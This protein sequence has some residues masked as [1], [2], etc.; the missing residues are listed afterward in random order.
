MLK[1][2]S[3]F[4]I[5]KSN[6]VM[7]DIDGQLAAKPLNTTVNEEGSTTIPRKGSTLFD[8]VEK[9]HF[10]FYSLTEKLPQ[11]KGIYGIYC[12]SNDTIYIGSANN[13]HARAIRHLSYLKRNAHHSQKLQRSYNKHGDDKFFIFLLEEV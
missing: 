7:N 9:A 11:N 2:N 10:K 13:F 4:V 3:I 12:I 1:N 8:K 6:Q 5:N